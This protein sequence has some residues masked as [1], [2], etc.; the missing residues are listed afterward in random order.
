MK[1]ATLLVLVAMTLI[2]CATP[3]AHQ[4][5]EILQHRQYLEEQ[6]GL[7]TVDSSDGISEVEAYKIGR[8]RFDTYQTGCGA[9]S[10]PVDLGD[11]W[12][13]ITLVGYAGQP[14]E[15]LLIRKSDGRTTIKKIEVSN[16]SKNE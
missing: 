3:E 10:T 7:I 12:R 14:C 4:R 9:V 15:E 1:R 13:V 11:C 8:D 16:V 6:A 2:G 5:Q